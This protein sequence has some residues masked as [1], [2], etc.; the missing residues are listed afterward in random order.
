MKHLTTIFALLSLAVVVTLSGCAPKAETGLTYQE[1][2]L[3]DVRTPQEFSE[4]SAPD[5]VNIPLDQ[6]KARVGEFEGKQQVVVF[7]LSGGRSSQAAAILQENGIQNVINGGTWQTVSNK[8]KEEAA[9]GAN[10]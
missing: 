1:S 9:Q 3:V 10:K 7:C 6:V 8:L 4:G 2:F 5:A